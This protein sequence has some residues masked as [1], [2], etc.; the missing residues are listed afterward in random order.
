MVA[1]GL[2]RLT[3]ARFHE[4]ERLVRD[5]LA[6]MRRRCRPSHPRIARATIALGQVLDESGAYDEAIPVL[7]EAVRLYDGAGSADAAI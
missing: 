5:G 1:L 7:E 2:L 4:A 6:M 3:Q